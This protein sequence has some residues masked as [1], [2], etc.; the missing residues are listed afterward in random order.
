V[1][2]ILL[3]QLDRVHTSEHT[4]IHVLAAPWRVQAESMHAG[5]RV[6]RQAAV[7]TREGCA[8][9]TLVSWL[10]SDACFSA[11]LTRTRAALGTHASATSTCT[12]TVAAGAQAVSLRVGDGRESG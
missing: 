9:L 8:P 1:G 3:P 2:H 5:H 7:C 12:G 6:G 10:R 4:C 11:S